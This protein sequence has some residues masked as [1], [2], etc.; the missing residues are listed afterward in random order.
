M[1]TNT[2]EYMRE[3]RQDQYKKY[4]DKCRKTRSKLYARKR[5][6]MS[7]EEVNEFDTHCCRAGQI[8]KL[9]DEINDPAIAHK[10]CDKYLNPEIV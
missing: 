7:H 8:R 10:I 4:P 2:T 5:Y 9:L 6:G 1:P 3:Y